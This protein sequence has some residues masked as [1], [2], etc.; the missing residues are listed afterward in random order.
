M[1]HKNKN[2]AFH[3]GLSLRTV[4]Y[5]RKL[6]RDK[7]GVHNKADLLTKAKELKII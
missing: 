4:E 7:W 3:L 1:G 6:V 5:Q 2:I